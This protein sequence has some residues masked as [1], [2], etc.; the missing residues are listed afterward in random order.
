MTGKNGM[1]TAWHF[2]IATQFVS[3]TERFDCSVIFRPSHFKKI[4]LS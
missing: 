2:A 1:V 4:V 3:V